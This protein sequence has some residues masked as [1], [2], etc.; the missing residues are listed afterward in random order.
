MNEFSKLDRDQMKNI[1]G[2]GVPPA[3]VCNVGASC[4]QGLDP[5]NTNA[6]FGVC[7]ET[8]HSGA[9]CFCVGENGTTRT[10]FCYIEGGIS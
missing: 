9:G 6:M 1:I 4:Y 10:D 8:S 7:S 3:K 2:G 5:T